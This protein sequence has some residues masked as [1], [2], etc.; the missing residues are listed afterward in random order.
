MEVVELFQDRPLKF[1]PGSSFHYA[2][3]GYVV[4]GRIIE[5][6]SGMTYEAYMQKHI[7]DRVGMK[8]T[9]VEKFDQAYDDKSQLYR[10]EKGKTKIARKNNLS[11]RVPGGGIYSN[12][13]DLLKFGE[14][15]LNHLFVKASTLEMMTEVYG[16]QGRRKSLWIR[17]V[18]LRSEVGWSGCL[19]T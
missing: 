18:S 9:G 15:I 2:S 14:G 17:L 13:E 3:Y 7:W 19:R 6:V 12:V 10:A 8:N 16:R 1:Q 4:L 11:N 5:Q